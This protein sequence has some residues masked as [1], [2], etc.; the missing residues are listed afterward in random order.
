MK[1]H[2]IDP[3]AADRRACALLVL[4]GAALTAL[5]A[6]FPAAFGQCGDGLL[7]A[8]LAAAAGLAGLYR[9]RPT[10]AG[11]A[12]RRRAAAGAR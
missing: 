12:A 6:L 10:R 4:L 2:R 5:V 3:H 8:P 1:A 9:L 7:L 11:R